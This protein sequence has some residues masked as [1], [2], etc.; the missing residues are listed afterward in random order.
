[1][2]GDRSV[3]PILHR[4]TLERGDA[5]KHLI[6]VVPTLCERQLEACAVED[7]PGRELE[8]GARPGIEVVAPAVSGY[9]GTG[10][11][12]EAGVRRI[13]QRI[14]VETRLVDV[15]SPVRPPAAADVPTGPPRA[16][17]SRRVRDGTEYQDATQDW[18]NK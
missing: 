11:F 18:C 17:L 16:A 9:F 8:H 15:G 10:V 7:E 6:D 12:V 5:A 4:Y 13:A 1:M 2:R 3:L 14:P